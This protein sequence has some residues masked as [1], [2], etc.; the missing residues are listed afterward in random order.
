MPEDGKPRPSHIYNKSSSIRE[1]VVK[2][3]PEP[4]CTREKTLKPLSRRCLNMCV[5][6][7]R[8]RFKYPLTSFIASRYY[9]F[10]THAVVCAMPVFKLSNY[11]MSFQ[12]PQCTSAGMVHVGILKVYTHYYRVHITCAIFGVI[13]VAEVCDHTGFVHCYQD[14]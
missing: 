7:L 3:P 13:D 9:S 12:R 11:S 10:A 8:D 14:T 4:R 6:V 2:R 1:A 5:K